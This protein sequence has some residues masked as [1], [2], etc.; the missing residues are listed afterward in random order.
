MKEPVK[1]THYIRQ[2]DK[3]KG[4]TTWEF[5]F[6]TYETGGEVYYE[7]PNQPKIKVGK[8]FVPHGGLILRNIHNSGFRMA[9]DVGV[10]GIYV[11][12]GPSAKENGFHKPKFLILGP[13]DF[14]QVDNETFTPLD[15][16]KA[17]D[18]LI[19]EKN[20]MD[21]I[22]FNM[23]TYNNDREK[24][25]KVTYK[26]TNKLFGKGSGYLYVVQKF[27]M[28]KY[29]DKPAHEPTGGLHAARLFPIT[30][31]I[32]NIPPNTNHE[33][34]DYVE[35]FRVDYRLHINLD[36]YIIDKYAPKTVIH[37]RSE[38]SKKT[39]KNVAGLFKDESGMNPV[40]CAGGGVAN[41]IFSSAEKPLVAEVVTEGINPY[42]RNFKWD[43]IH[44][45]GYGKNGSLGSTPG[46]FHAVHIHW[47]WAK[48]MQSKSALSSEAG[49]PQFAGLG[50]Q[51]ELTDPNIKNQ[52]LRIAVVKNEGIPNDYHEQKSEVYKDFFINLRPNKTPIDIKGGD[53]LIL[54]YSSEVKLK[55]S[56]KNSQKGLNCSI[57][58]HGLF[59]AHE[60]EPNSFT[61]GTTANFN[62]NP[63]TPNNKTW[64]RYPEK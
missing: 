33:I 47:R 19:V 25:L 46:S 22:G 39:I 44:W 42:S 45:W 9:Y 1:H 24:E 13:P 5:D 58:V 12:P 28:T 30:Q 60:V 21:S 59:F 62:I 41:I 15:P 16:N 10:I 27:I 55:N 35:S 48:G 37:T 23:S 40:Y 26:S 53:D 61:K 32:Y 63:D 38:K 31:L 36:T 8:G 20:R 2:K 3:K 7:T 17:Y 50:N 49:K 54:Y 18:P 56:K 14:I 11:F 64:E 57:F 29:S 52:I 43:N 51:G 34:E 6:D 4:S